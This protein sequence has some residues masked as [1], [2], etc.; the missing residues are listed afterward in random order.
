MV[1]TDARL[2]LGRDVSFAMYEGEQSAWTAKHTS[3]H[4]WL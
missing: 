3:Q 4:E 1:S 2:E